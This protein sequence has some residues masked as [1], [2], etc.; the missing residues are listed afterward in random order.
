MRAGQPDYSVN[1]QQNSAN[2]NTQIRLLPA[3]GVCPG[4]LLEVRISTPVGND[5]D[6]EGFVAHNCENSL[7]IHAESILVSTPPSDRRNAD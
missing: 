2:N 7:A 4:G 1:W 3:S 5:C 6:R